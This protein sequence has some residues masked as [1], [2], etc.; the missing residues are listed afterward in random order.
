MFRFLADKIG[1]TVL[2]ISQL[3]L[4]NVAGTDPWFNQVT[5]EAQGDGLF[6]STVLMDSYTED[7]DRMLQSGDTLVLHFEVDLVAMENE[8]VVTI[9]NWEHQFR[10]SILQDRYQLYF[11]ER[12]EWDNFY[13]LAEAKSNWVSLRRARLCDLDLLQDDAEYFLRISAFMDNMQLPGLTDEL[14]LMAFWNRI[15][16]IHTTNPFQKRSLVL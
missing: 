10:Y 1:A 3:V 16:P 13:T 5:L 9:A 2:A 8:R 7:L 15:R 12:D 11:S 6:L 14:N 4:T